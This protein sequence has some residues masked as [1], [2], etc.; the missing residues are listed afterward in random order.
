MRRVLVFGGRN[1]TDKKA[2]YNSL[3]LMAEWKQSDIDGE[4]S[5]A[6]LY[7]IS[8]CARGADTLALDWAQFRECPTAEYPADWD[9]YGKVAGFL[10]NQ[11]MLSEDPDIGLMFPGGNGTRDMQRRLFKARIPIVNGI[12]YG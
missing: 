12:V 5:T 6:S 1:F 9:Q 7:V 4:G 11:E 3:D 10:R 8:G 2:V